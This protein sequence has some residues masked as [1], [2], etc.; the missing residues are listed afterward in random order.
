MTAAKLI[1]FRIDDTVTAV[2]KLLCLSH[3][4]QN[5]RIE[6]LDASLNDVYRNFVLEQYSELDQ[7]KQ[8]LM[9]A[10]HSFGDAKDL[11]ADVKVEVPQ[12]D[13][14]PIP[15]QIKAFQ[16][17]TKA[18]SDEYRERTQTIQTA[19]AELTRLFDRLGYS[20]DDRGEFAEDSRRDL[21]QGRLAR[22][23]QR[24]LSLKDEKKRRREVLRT[25]KM[26]HQKLIAE[27]Q[28]P[29]SSSI[30]TLLNEENLTQ[31]AIDE[32]ET[33]NDELQLVKADRE[34]EIM[35]LKGELAELYELL[36]VDHRERKIFA[37]APTEPNVQAL[38]QEHTLLESQTE[39]RLAT[40]LSKCEGE[41]QRLC[42][43]LQLADWKRPRYRGEDQS[44]AIS[45]Y[46]NAIE[47]LKALSLEKSQLFQMAHDPERNEQQFEAALEHYRS[48]TGSRVNLANKENATKTEVSLS[49]TLFARPELMAKTS[50]K[51]LFS[52]PIEQPPALPKRS[53]ATGEVRRRRLSP[54][55]KHRREVVLRARLPFKT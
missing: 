5:Q 52:D 38:Q 45:F 29:I 28:D 1:K 3:D 19:F 26:R 20:R 21:T 15:R 9:D 48:R 8:A 55:A 32:L 47:D 34:C 51:S 27:T 17:A 42:A 6:K 7:L 43:D 54:Q 25:L 49:S 12:V 23:Q 10:K 11:Y 40:I 50:A 36:I 22:I 53:G 44:A 39:T 13:S 16:K 24:I 2:W 46:Q 4:E 14:L 41:V 35:R 30:A 18:L 33:A 31:S 37:T